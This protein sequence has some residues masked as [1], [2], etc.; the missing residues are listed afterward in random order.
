ME[1][2]KLGKLHQFIQCRFGFFL[3]KKHFQ[4]LCFAQIPCINAYMWN[5][6][7]GTD[8]PI[9]R[10]GIETQ[11]V[12]T[13]GEGEGERNWESGMDL[14]TLPC[15]EQAAGAEPLYSTGWGARLHSETTWGWGGAR[16]SS[17]GRGHMCT[18]GWFMPLC[19]RSQHNV[20]KQL[21]SNL[22]NLNK[23][24]LRFSLIHCRKFGGHRE[25]KSLTI[26]P[27][28][29]D[30]PQPMFSYFSFQYFS[31]KIFMCASTHTPHQ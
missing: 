13:V 26:P 27:I 30:Q 12:A 4:K 9:C 7:N 11:T 22:K 25:R 2:I 20:G 3:R 10:A 15:I 5:P 17:G 28:K 16:G 6:E 8:E 29:E 31:V 1:N 14:Y 19:S 24:K 18:Q 21:W 23:K